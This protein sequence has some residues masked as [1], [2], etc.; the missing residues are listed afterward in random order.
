MTPSGLDPRP[1]L[2]LIAGKTSPAAARRLG[3]SESLIR[4]WRLGR[5]RI[6]RN[7]GDRIAIE[8]GRHPTNLWPEEW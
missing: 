3:V 6:S 8:L 2:E 5:R 1:V 7:L 4:Y